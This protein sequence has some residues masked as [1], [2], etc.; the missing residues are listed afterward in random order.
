M[1]RFETAVNPTLLRGT[2][3]IL[4][5]ILEQG[6]WKEYPI[7]L[8]RSPD[9][10]HQLEDDKMEKSTEKKLSKNEKKMD[11]WRKKIVEERFKE[12]ENIYRETF[13]IVY[14]VMHKIGYDM[15]YEPGIT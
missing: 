7:P 8:P 1:K 4:L 14:E 3:E 13:P 11:T 2:F 6:L 5:L 9:P 15:V 12:M 10:P